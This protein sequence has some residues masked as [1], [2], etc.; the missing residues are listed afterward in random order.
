MR[1]ELAHESKAHRYAAYGK[2]GACAPTVRV[3]TWGDLRRVRFVLRV[4]DPDRTTPGYQGPGAAASCPLHAMNW[5][6]SPATH[7][8]RRAATRAV[9]MQKSADAVVGGQVSGHRR[10]EQR[11]TRSRRAV[12]ARIAEPARVRCAGGW[13]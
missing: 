3:L 7:A 10:A 4:T 9:T 2:C 13:A 8:A 1:G 6:Q 5:Q 11:D 12:L